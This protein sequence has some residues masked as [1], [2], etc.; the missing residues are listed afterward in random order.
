MREY[1]HEV[2]ERG[3]LDKAADEGAKGRGR[4]H[5]DTSQHRGHDAAKQGCVERVV[6]SGADARKTRA[7]GSRI[8]AGECPVH[9]TRRD[10]AANAAEKGGDEDEDQQAKGATTGA[11]GLAI[12]FGNG[13]GTAADDGG[14]VVDG[15]EDCNEVQD[16]CQKA[17][18]HLGDHGFGNVDA[19]AVWNQ[20]A[21]AG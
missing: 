1:G 2:R 17:N 13:Q 3:Q 6:E 14:E 18:A 20:T 4:A 12:D 9:A 11:G 15:V 21:L 19:W 10:V 16:G 8:V 5:V 7:E